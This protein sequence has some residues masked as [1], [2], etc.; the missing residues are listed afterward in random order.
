MKIRLALSAVL[1]FLTVAASDLHAQTGVIKSFEL[2]G[3]VIW[4]TTLS[5]ANLGYSIE[6]AS[7]ATGPWT[8]SWA[9][10]SERDVTNTTMRANVPL[11]YRV[12]QQPVLR[13]TANPATLLSNAN[14]ST[15]SVTGGVSPYTWT[16]MDAFYGDVDNEHVNPAFYQRF[17]Q[18]NNEVRVTDSAGHTNYVLILQP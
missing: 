18:G 10:L 7:V 8:N 2:N 1:F 14:Y 12:A 16:S 3:T 6:W 4:T 15:L 13:V 9:S 5:R 11:F 17:E